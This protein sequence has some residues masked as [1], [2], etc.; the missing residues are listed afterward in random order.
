MY[1]QIFK[2]KYQNEAKIQYIIIIQSF[3]N[4]TINIMVYC[5]IFLLNK[6]VPPLVHIYAFKVLICLLPVYMFVCLLQSSPSS[7]SRLNKY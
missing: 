3:S 4:Y 2:Y 5:F 7:G 1:T 6:E